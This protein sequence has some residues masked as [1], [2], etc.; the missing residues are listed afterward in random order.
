MLIAY[1]KSCGRFIRDCAVYAANVRQLRQLDEY[2]TNEQLNIRPTQ[3]DYLS[4]DF[5]AKTATENQ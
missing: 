2:F 5:Y 3:F 1:V 4:Y